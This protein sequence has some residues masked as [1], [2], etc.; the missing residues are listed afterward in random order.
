M[1]QVRGSLGIRG[2]TH[3]SHALARGTDLVTV[4]DNL[5]HASIAATSLYLHGDEMR[6]ARQLDQAFGTA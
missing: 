5:R 3:G 1:L 4:R 6:R 2:H